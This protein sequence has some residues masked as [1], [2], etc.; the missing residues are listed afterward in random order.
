MIATMTQCCDGVGLVKRR[1]VTW[2][3]PL[4]LDSG[5]NLA[6]ITLSY[7]T[8]GELSPAR[9]NAILLLHALSGDAHA[10]GRHSQADRKPGWWDAMVGPGRAFD[11]TRYFVICSNVIGGGPGRAPPSNRG[12]ASPR[13]PRA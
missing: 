4:P 10:A 8:Y 2:Q 7:E 1:Y 13:P 11:T 6:P 12:P 9:D 3:E 5:A